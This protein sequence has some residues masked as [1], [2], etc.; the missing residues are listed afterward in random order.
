[1]CPM[2]LLSLLKVKATFSV[3]ALSACQLRQLNAA[4]EAM[5]QKQMQR[6]LVSWNFMRLNFLGYGFKFLTYFLNWKRTKQPNYYDD[7]MHTLI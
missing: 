7:I 4:K 5:S 3:Y 1:M 2:F 6:K